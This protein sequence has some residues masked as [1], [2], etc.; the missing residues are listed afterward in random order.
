MKAV[1]RSANVIVFIGVSTG[2]LLF[3]IFVHN[4]F[5]LPIGYNEAP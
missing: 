2:L 4:N 3:K 1:A 5:A